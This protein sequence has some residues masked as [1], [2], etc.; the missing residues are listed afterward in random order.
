[1]QNRLAYIFVLATVVIDAIGIGIIFPVM[2]ELLEEVTGGTLSQAALWGGVLATSFA[3]MQFVFGPIVGNLSD[4]FGRRPVML[5]ALAVM[6]VDYAIMAVAGTIWI[7]LI[8]RIVAG[9]TA[10][11]H[12][13][14]T[15]YMADISEKSQRARN[16]GLIGAAF[17]IGFIAG[18]FLGSLLSTLGVRAPFWGAAALSA[19]N[20]A[21]GYFVLPES[22]TDRI[23]RPFSWT[24]ANPLAS[25]RA[26]GRL[27]GVGR[28]LTLYLVYN[29]ALHVYE[30]VWAFYGKARF[31]WD[32]FMIGVSLAVYGLFFALVQ[33]FAVGPM[34]RVFGE[35]RAAFCGLLIEFVACV[36]FGFLTSGML[37]LAFTA[38]AALGSVAGPAMQGLMSNATPDDQQ[39]ELQGVVASLMAVGMILSPMVMTGTFSWFTR[40]GAAIYAP[41]APFLLAAALLVVCVIILVAP[42]RESAPS[43]P[44]A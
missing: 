3:V 31:D 36:I 27:P 25:F 18:P 16:F 29:V 30:A 43:E 35:H 32:P 17:G 14:A 19:A 2:P 41:G 21:F 40:P 23:R 28:L 4:H 38:F 44:L 8:G 22:V 11:T 26:I 7:L 42:S 6:A 15:A 34:T 9:I 10:A 12:T 24:R 39:G 13:T 1:M 5:T 37:A 33:A 20:L